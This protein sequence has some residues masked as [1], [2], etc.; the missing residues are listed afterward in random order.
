MRI[1]FMGSPELAVPSLRVVKE[2]GHVVGVI[3]QPPRASGRGRKLTPSPISREAGQ[4]GIVVMTP[5]NLKTP[6]IKEALLKLK[7]DIAVVMAYGKILPPDILAVPKL[8]CVNVHTS[9]LPELRGAA[10]IQW[11][12][13]RGYQTTGVTLMQMDAGMD[14]GPILLQETTA[15]G[16]EE[17]AGELG[18]R[19]AQMGADLLQEGLP[20]I[21]RGELFPIAQDNSQ[22]TYAPLLTKADGLIDWSLPAEEIANRVRGFSPWPGTYT[23]RAGSRLLVTRARALEEENQHTPGRILSAGTEGIQVACG[24]GRLYVLAVK[25][26]GKREMEISEFLAGHRVEP[27]EVLGGEAIRDKG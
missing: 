21:E 6:E 18:A 19:L 12:I 8:G 2:A 1:L 15:I 20:L 5:E 17:T 24:S 13:A 9:I 16:A 10:P 23:T 11:A 7:P 26:E 14:T 27:G 22:A 4:W 3:T 25:P